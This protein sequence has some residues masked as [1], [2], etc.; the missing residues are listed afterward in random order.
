LDC[1]FSQISANKHA[2]KA[3]ILLYALEFIQQNQCVHPCE[4]A[5]KRILNGF[6]SQISVNKRADKAQILMYALEFIQRK[7]AQ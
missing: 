4:S 5:S 3:Q 7:S 6:F 2:D 1:F